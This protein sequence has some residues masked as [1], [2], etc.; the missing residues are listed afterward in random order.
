MT[1]SILA[2][3]FEHHVWATGRL[4]DACLALTP[5]QLAT[6]V[7]G[8]YGS[9]VDTARHIVSTDASFLAMLTGERVPR[10]DADGLDLAALRAEVAKH[11]PVWASILAG[12][13]DPDTDVVRRRPDGSEAH[14]PLSIRLA[15]AINHGTDH[16]SQICTAITSL[17]IEPPSIDVASSHR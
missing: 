15:Q 14:M 10:L 3:A 16:R 13:P 8:T 12:D 9:I 6:S 2:D 7:P 11:G 4:L 5:E 1:R 17:G